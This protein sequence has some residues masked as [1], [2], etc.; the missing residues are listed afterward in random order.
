MSAQKQLSNEAHEYQQARPAPGAN[1]RKRTTAF[2]MKRCVAFVGFLGTCAGAA[3]AILS[4]LPVPASTSIY[5][6]E[7][8]SVVKL[9]EKQFEFLLALT[10]VNKGNKS[11]MVRRPQVEFTSDRQ[12][13]RCLDD[14]VFTDK[15]GDVS[16]PLIL[17]KDSPM[18]LTCIIKWQPSEA[19]YKRNSEVSEGS[20]DIDPAAMGRVELT[21]PGE[22]NKWRI[23]RTF[24]LLAE[25]TIREMK[26][27]V[28]HPIRY[29]YLDADS[30]SAEH[31]ATNS[32]AQP[33]SFISSQGRGYQSAF[34]GT[35][36]LAYLASVAVPASPAQEG[37][38]HYAAQGEIAS[39][40]D[41]PSST[42]DE[43]IVNIRPCG[44]AEERVVFKAP[45]KKRFMGSLPCGV[46]MV[47]IEKL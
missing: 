3:A 2:W 28:P 7:L 27:G 25:E 5:T 43:A 36:G 14:V 41:I 37:K 19:Y 18:Q 23:E 6:D 44:G 29:M 39:G 16:F 4:M 9:E 15:Q 46:Q 12:L 42:P 13:V 10:L 26:P 34:I 24:A 8:I 32:D 35:G 21:W 31:R 45:F 20:Q 22:N 38:T 30:P 1:R 17:Q 11:D 33:A 47:Q 40:K